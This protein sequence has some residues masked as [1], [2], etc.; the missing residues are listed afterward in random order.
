MTTT[1]T[2][3]QSTQL[4][5]WQRLASVALLVLVLGQ[6]LGWW[7][8]MA[9]QRLEWLSYDLRVQATLSGAKD[10]SLVIIDIDERK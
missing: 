6:M 3:P 2:R 4:L 1:H 5:M 10:P 8:S 9:L 7:S